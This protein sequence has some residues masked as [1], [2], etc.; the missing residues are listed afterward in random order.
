[1]RINERMVANAR[2][3]NN[4]TILL[5]VSKIASSTV[6]KL[7]ADNEEI[8]HTPTNVKEL[9]ENTSML[10]NIVAMKIKN[11]LLKN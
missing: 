2:E 9:E 10:D 3:I 11:S 5:A 6:N 7:T 8:L 4:E 1:M